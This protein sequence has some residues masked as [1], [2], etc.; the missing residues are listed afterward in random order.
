MDAYTKELER[1][2]TEVLLPAYIEHHRLLGHKD[3]TK[4]IN[5]NLVDAM[6]KKRQ[7]PILLQR[8]S[9]E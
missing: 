6:K 9:Y 8:Q 4:N 2:I 1:L 3:A 5:K 7:I